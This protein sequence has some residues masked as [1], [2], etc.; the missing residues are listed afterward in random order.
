ML[1]QGQHKSGRILWLWQLP[2]SHYMFETR[3]CE[4]DFPGEKIERV[5]FF[6]YGKMWNKKCFRYSLWMSKLATLWIKCTKSIGDKKRDEKSREN[7]DLHSRRCWRDFVGRFQ[8]WSVYVVDSIWH[9]FLIES[10][11]HSMRIFFC[12][13]RSCMYAN[14]VRFI[15]VHANMSIFGVIDIRRE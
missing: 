1:L 15:D 8:L 10:E 4:L 5:G 12:E 14:W 3:W 9:E 7:D 2:Y 11:R 13:M 6:F